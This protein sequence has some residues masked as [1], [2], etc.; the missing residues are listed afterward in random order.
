ME[1]IPND[2]KHF[3]NKGEH[4][5]LNAEEQI[6]VES[7]LAWDEPKKI[8]VNDP[9]FQDNLLMCFKLINN[10]EANWQ[11]IEIELTRLNAKEIPAIKNSNRFHIGRSWWAVAA[12]VLLALGLTWLFINLRSGLREL[13]IVKTDTLSTSVGRDLTGTL[14][15]GSTVILNAQSLLT[16]PAKFI[17]A[18]RQ[19]MLIGEAYFEV[20]QKPEKPFLLKLREASVRVTGT[21]FNIKSYPGDTTITATLITGELEVKNRDSSKKIYP[22]QQAIISNHR[23]IVK[24]DVN[25]KHAIAWKLGEINL[26]GESIRSVMDQVKHWYGVDYIIK[27]EVTLNEMANSIKKPKT[28]TKLLEILNGVISN[29]H[30][31]MDKNRVVVAAKP[32]P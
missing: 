3:L 9:D 31:S 24:D 32:N 14:P 30:F 16:Y 25:V 1:V 13:A 27:D 29:M 26:E 22:G 15:D 4:E 6:L 23:I 5:A 20:K 12:V 11:K 18:E 10:E 2:F 21:S 7:F 8:N 19:V 28:L 17:G